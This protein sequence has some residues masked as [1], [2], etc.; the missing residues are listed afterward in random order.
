MT[1]EI[2]Y[3]KARKLDD[4][5]FDERPEL[6]LLGHRESP[7]EGILCLSRSDFDAMT[8]RQILKRFNEYIDSLLDDI[9]ND[10]PVEIVVES[11]RLSGASCHSNG[12][13]LEMFCAVW[14]VGTET[15]VEKTEW[16]SLLSASTISCLPG[17]NFWT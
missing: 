14:S 9:A 15:A 12:Q 6:V 10:R 2:T 8:G 3:K 13:P 4:L 17:K 5:F 16:A 1:I 7:K 11:H